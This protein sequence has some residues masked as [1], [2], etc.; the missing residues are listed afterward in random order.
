MKTFKEYI[1]ESNITSGSWKFLE[2]FMKKQPGFLSWDIEDDEL[3]IKFKKNIQAIKAQKKANDSFTEISA[4]GQ[5]S[6]GNSEIRV[7]LNQEALDSL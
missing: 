6:A 7:E 5:S 2:D 1:I 4:F 3:I